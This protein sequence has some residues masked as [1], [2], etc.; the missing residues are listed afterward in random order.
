[1]TRAIVAGQE[2]T[3]TRA[4]V[5][6]DPSATVE[7]PLVPVKESALETVHPLDRVAGV[8]GEVVPDPDPAAVAEVASRTLDNDQRAAQ[9][10]RSGRKPQ[11]EQEEEARQQPGQEQQ[12]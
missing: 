8:Q 3:L 10:R 12:L 11:E 4:G 5:P 9:Q 7:P 6:L 2:A 1:M